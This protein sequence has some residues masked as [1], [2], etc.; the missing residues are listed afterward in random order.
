M[1]TML[2]HKIV[3]R[4]YD[5]FN[6]GRFIKEFTKKEAAEKYAIKHSIYYEVRCVNKV[7]IPFNIKN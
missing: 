7:Y 1:D 2:K 5:M 3:W 6:N 4:I